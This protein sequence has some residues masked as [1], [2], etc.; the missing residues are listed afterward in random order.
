M[1]AGGHNHHTHNG[2]PGSDRPGIHTA[3]H[4]AE[5]LAELLQEG[6]CLIGV[7]NDLCGDDGAGPAIARALD[8][9]VPWAVL[10]TQSCP[11]SY[12]MKI[13]KLAPPTVIL[14][15]ALEMSAEPGTVDLV[16]AENITGQGPSTHGPAPLAFLDLLKMLHP[17]RQ[18]VL[19]IQPARGE[20]GD[21]M[22]E[23]VLR[24]VGMVTSAFLA[25]ADRG[26]S[27]DPA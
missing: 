23:P 8:G 16:E 3:E 5:H 27:R 10:D 4:L 11:E 13:V 12:L 1:S 22:S 6:T 2:A 9:K 21:E 20:V 25:A 18:A 19:G 24:A 15:D 7:G 26:P 14:I 17:C